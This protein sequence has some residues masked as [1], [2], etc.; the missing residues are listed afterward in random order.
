MTGGES[1]VGIGLLDTDADALVDIGPSPDWVS[2]E[3]MFVLYT[4]TNLDAE[5]LRYDG[6]NWERVFESDD[7]YGAQLL[8]MVDCSPEFGSDETVFAALAGGPNILV[9]EDSGTVWAETRNAP[10]TMASWAIVDAETI[11]AGGAADDTVYVTDRQGRRAWDDYEVAAGA[12]TIISLAVWG[13][14]VVCGTDAGEVYISEDFAETW[15][16]VGAV[17]DIG[18]TYVGF[19][20]DFGTNNTIYAASDGTR[21]LAHA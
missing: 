11:I 15:D 9:S 8:D 18:D 16:I 1:W 7:Q 19:D 6:S 13:D 3:V 17:I 4:N 21:T 14:T 12:G 10:A 2:D 5:I 20:T